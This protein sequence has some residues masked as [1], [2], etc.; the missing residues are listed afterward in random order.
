MGSRGQLRAKSA[1]SVLN[2]SFALSCVVDGALACGGTT[3]LW[4]VSAKAPPDNGGLL[5]ELACVRGL[6]ILIFEDANSPRI[7]G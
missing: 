7:P 1:G 5:S 4:K 3:S 2:H 6:P